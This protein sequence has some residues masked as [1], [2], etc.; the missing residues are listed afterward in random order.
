MK[1]T[2]WKGQESVMEALLHCSF[3]AMETNL[4]NQRIEPV[5]W[6]IQQEIISILGHRVKLQVQE[7]SLFLS[8]AVEE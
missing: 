8:L 1:R 3:P 6:I 4:I 2:P 7:T 5:H